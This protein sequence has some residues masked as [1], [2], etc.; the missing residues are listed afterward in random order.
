MLKDASEERVHRL[1]TAL[2]VYGDATGQRIHPQKSRI[3]LLGSTKPAAPDMAPSAIA[4]IPVRDQ[5]VTLGVPF[6]D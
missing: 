3:F 6:A 5:V 1:L 2:A 4:G